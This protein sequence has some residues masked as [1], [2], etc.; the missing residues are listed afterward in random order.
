MPRPKNSF[1][2][3]E[4]L[5]F[6]NTISKIQ[7]VTAPRERITPAVM[8]VVIEMPMVSKSIYSTGSNNA[9]SKTLCIGPERGFFLKKSETPTR[10]RTTRVTFSS[11][12]NAKLIKKRNARM[13]STSTVALNAPVKNIV[14]P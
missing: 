7:V 9:V 14:V 1:C 3:S 13:S 11:Q 5:S 2:K 10:I 12:K 4:Q 8:P 6:K